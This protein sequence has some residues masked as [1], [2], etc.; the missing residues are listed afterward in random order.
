VP[1]HGDPYIRVQRV[2]EGN[3]GCHLDLHLDLDAE[4][5]DEAGARA[6]T[7]GARARRRL[8]DLVVLESP[9][10][11][12]FCLVPWE[13]EST[14]PGPVQLDS[15]GA[16]R[17]DQLCLDIPSAR[18][19]AECDFWERLTGWELRAGALPEFAFLVRPGGIPVRL[20]FQR[21]VSAG[22]HDKVRAHVDFA[23]AD[24]ARLAVRHAAAGARALATFPLWLTMAD[25]TGHAYCLTKRDPETGRLPDVP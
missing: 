21:R 6:A 13:Q 24:A 16:S 11:F 8:D 1:R 4:S 15:G 17:V 22:K 3:G 14:V 10:G 5:L 12:T 18:F 20:L 25:P 9:G 19:E 2:D 7:L 23:C